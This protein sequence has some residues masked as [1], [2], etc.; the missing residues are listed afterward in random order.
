MPRLYDRNELFSMIRNVI[1]SR[2]VWSIGELIEGNISYNPDLLQI[3]AL[4]V[5]FT[6]EELGKILLDQVKYQHKYLQLWSRKFNTPAHKFYK[7]EDFETNDRKDHG[8]DRIPKL[9]FKWTE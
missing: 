3:S 2:E 8:S 4:Y 9:K 5:K 1:P 6:G 7:R